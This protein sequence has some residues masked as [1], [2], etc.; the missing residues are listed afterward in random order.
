[1]SSRAA[2]VGRCVVQQALAWLLS[3]IS[4][5]ILPQVVSCTTHYLRRLLKS[6]YTSQSN[7]G[8]AASPTGRRQA[9]RVWEWGRK[10]LGFAVVGLHG[11]VVGI[12]LGYSC[13]RKKSS[14]RYIGF[15]GLLCG[16]R[17]VDKC[18]NFQPTKVHLTC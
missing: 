17:E 2:D 18:C 10:E 7:N 6:S 4:P 9:G 14:R 1:M 16:H 8:S 11:L 15:S 12:L 3:S 13:I 5:L